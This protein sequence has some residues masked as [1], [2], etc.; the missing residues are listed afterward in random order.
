L[1]VM[2]TL[3]FQSLIPSGGIVET[4]ARDGH[5]M[6]VLQ[7]GASGHYVSKGK[8]NGQ[9][10]TFLVDTGATDVAIPNRL[11]RALDLEFGAATVVM[12]A[13]GPVKAWMTRL[14]SVS[15]GAVSR[16]NVRATITSGPL[17][18]VLLGMSF[19][20]YFNLSQQ[21]DKLIISTGDQT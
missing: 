4:G 13:N 12:T 11:A 3:I 15:I 6:V 7:Q 18:E 21:G 16:S 1:L 17:N 19:L 2:L 14:D 9:P 20:K 10:V 8:I 5:S